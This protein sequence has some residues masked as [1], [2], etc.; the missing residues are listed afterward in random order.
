MALLSDYILYF[1]AEKAIK[2][3]VPNTL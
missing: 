2:I 1:S 3:D